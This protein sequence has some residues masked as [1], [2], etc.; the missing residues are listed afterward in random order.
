MLKDFKAFIMRGNVGDMADRIIGL[1]GNP[2]KLAQ[3]GESARRRVL[4]YYTWD[5]VVKR[6]KAA[7]QQR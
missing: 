2:Q 3:L 4:G 5:Q 7:M 6:L 1:L